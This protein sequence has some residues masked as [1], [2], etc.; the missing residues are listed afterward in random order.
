MQSSSQE[1]IGI[2]AEK[3]NTVCSGP[4]YP[5]FQYQRVDPC[6]SVK[7]NLNLCVVLVAGLCKILN[8]MCRD[9]PD[10]LFRIPTSSLKLELIDTGR[11]FHLKVL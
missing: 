3:L 10:P 6:S 2:I 4:F 11:E 8:W 9:K 5:A 1:R 7:I